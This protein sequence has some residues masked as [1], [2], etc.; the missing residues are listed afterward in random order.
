LVGPEYLQPGGA[1]SIHDTG[2]QR[3]FRT[4]HSHVNILALRECDQ[5][6]NGSDGDIRHAVFQCRARIARRNVHLLHLGA[7]RKPPSHRVLAT[8]GTYD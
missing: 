6:G 8:A 7:L 3:A 5:L 2:C 4:D 1:E